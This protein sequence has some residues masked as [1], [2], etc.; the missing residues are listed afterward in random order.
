M[1]HGFDRWSTSRH[2]LTPLI[3]DDSLDDLAIVAAVDVIHVEGVLHES[4]DAFFSIPS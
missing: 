1:G 2:V 3:T 4:D